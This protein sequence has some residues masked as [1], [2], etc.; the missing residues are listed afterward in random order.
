MDFSLTDDEELFRKT[1][2]EFCE[3]KLQ[4]RSREIDDRE[5]IP[6]DILR[7]MA[8]LRLLGI[9]IPDEY[10]GAGSSTTMAALAGIEIGRGDISMATAVFYLLEAGWS[11][12]LSKYGTQEAKREVFPKVV[13]GEAF[14]GIATTE[15]GGGSDLASMKTTGRREGDYFI[16]NGEKVFVSGVA[17]ASRMGGGHL[18]LVKT[19]PAAGHRG[20][21]FIY[22][23]INSAGITTTIFSHMGRMGISTGGISYKEARVPA[24]YLLG[25]EN[26]GFYYAM[27][28]FTAARTLVSAACIG[29]AERALEIGTDYVKRREAFG[30]PIGKFEAIQ[31]E[32]AEQYCQI[33]MA[34]LLVLRAAWMLDKYPQPDTYIASDINKTVAA[35]KLYAPE[36]AF[37]T[38]KK[39]MM[40][41]GAA[42]YSKENDLEMA[43][44]GL[45]SYLVGAE[46]AANI[47]RTILVRELLG[48]EFVAYR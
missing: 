31:F 20:M 14:L 39:A 9:T 7:E 12:I 22:V 41:Y 45:M 17:E 2:R 19:D 26:R 3:R 29:A 34:K 11:A 40:W 25:Q 1:I 36:V 10:G 38:V 4:P 21:S 8:S 35:A 37:T 27:D 24:K 43:M 30:S 23:P 28:G 5:R 13:E 32:L 18:T 48:P 6:E 42:G 46:G 15:P 44:R 33:E 16:L 47:M